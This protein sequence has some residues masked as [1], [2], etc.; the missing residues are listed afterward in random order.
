MAVRNKQMPKNMTASDI[1]AVNLKGLMAMQGVSASEMQT[2]MG[3]GETTY[4]KRMKRPY[5][6]T[7]DNVQRAAKRLGVTVADMTGKVMSVGGINV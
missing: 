4:Y 2:L 7:M 5:E 6:F 1:F 3:I